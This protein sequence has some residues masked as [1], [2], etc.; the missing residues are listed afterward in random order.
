MVELRYCV[1]ERDIICLRN[2]TGTFAIFQRHHVLQG[3][4]HVLFCFSH[5]FKVFVG[6][7]CVH[8]PNYWVMFQWAILPTVLELTVTHHLLYRLPLTIDHLPTT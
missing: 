8:I 3:L 2:P 6:Y 5:D 4:V 7:F 1:Q